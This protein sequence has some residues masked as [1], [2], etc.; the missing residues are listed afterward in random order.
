VIDDH[1][2]L[3]EPHRFWDDQPVPKATDQLKL[4]ESE[5]N[6][7]IEVKTLSEVQQDPYVLPAEY[8]WC[9][10]DLNNESVLDEVYNLLVENYVEDDE[11]MFRFDY[12]RPFLRWAL[13]MPGG[14]PNW[15]VGVRGGKAQKLY[16]M[17]TG[18]PVRMSLNNTQVMC[19]EINFLCVHK[20]LRA[21]RLAPI[22]IKEITRRVNLKE[23]WQAIYT[24]GARIPTPITGATYWHRSLNP[25]KLLDVKFSHKSKKV[26]MASHIKRHALPATSIWPS[27]RPMQEEDIPK[28]TELLTTYLS[29]RKIHIHFTVE[30]VKHFFLPQNNVVYTYVEGPVGGNLTDMFSFYCLPS[31]VL[32][33]DTHNMLWVAYSY[34]NVSTTDRLEQGMEEILIRAKELEFDVFNC[35]DVMDNE[36]FLEKLKFGKGDGELHYYLYNWRMRDVTP[37]DLGIVLV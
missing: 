11:A 9:D 16:G 24:A 37:S 32:N 26:S 12:S 10:L 27:L 35:L 15:I 28:V 31:Q 33:H 23:I 20:G 13:L 34:Y 14:E 5:F 22:L 6:K 30:E 18:I 17:I 2:S 19:A 25:K 8:N 1:I 36:P 4:S 7:P 29:E 3:F 21:K